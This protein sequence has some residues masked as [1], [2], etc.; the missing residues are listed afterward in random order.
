MFE[1]IKSKITYVQ[2]MS[3]ISALT[4]III[5]LKQF[6]LNVIGVD[7]IEMLSGAIWTILVIIGIAVKSDDIHKDVNSSETTKVFK[8]K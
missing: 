7:Q 5:V 1:W 8:D 4:A 2:Y 6:G 3:I